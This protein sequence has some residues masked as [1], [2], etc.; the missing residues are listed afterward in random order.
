[1]IQHA[2]WRAMQAH[3]WSIFANHR[4]VVRYEEEVI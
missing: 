4:F 1:M 2:D 3:P